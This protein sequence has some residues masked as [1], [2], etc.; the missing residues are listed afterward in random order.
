VAKCLLNNL[1]NIRS[2]FALARLT[3]K[4]F[5]L[6]LRIELFTVKRKL[7]SGQLLASGKSEGETD[8]PRQFEA[9]GWNMTS[10]MAPAGVQRWPSKH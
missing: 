3:S 2:N 9:I 10:G 1:F 8:K 4:G 6:S 7:T 5:L